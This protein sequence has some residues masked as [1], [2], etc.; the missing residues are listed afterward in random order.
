MAKCEYCGRTIT[1]DMEVCE[2]CGAP[3]PESAFEEEKGTTQN[4]KTASK[5]SGYRL[6]LVSCGTCSESKAEDLLEDLLG[7]GSGECREIVESLPSEAACGLTSEQAVYLAQAMTEYGMQVSIYDEDGPADLEWKEDGNVFDSNGNYV[8]KFA[9]ILGM[10]TMANRVTRR[11]PWTEPIDRRNIFVS[12]CP[13]PHEPIHRRRKPSIL[14]QLFGMSDSMMRR[15]PEPPRRRPDPMMQREPEPPRRRP[16]PMMQRDPGP[17]RRRTE[18][19]PFGGPGSSR[20]REPDMR[21]NAGFDPGMGA[22]PGSGRSGSRR[23]PQNEGR[24]H[25]PGGRGPF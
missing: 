24:Q 3:I 22:R 7:Y 6:I 4:R 16:E 15:E 8:K 5:S 12:P 21:R 11:G 9:E 19:M 10:L 20:G 18:Q 1:R 23:P 2:G 17:S 14:E 13:P 25:G